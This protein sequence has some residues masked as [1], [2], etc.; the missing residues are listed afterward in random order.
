MLLGTH[1]PLMHHCKEKKEIHITFLGKKITKQEYI[2]I[3]TTV[4][5]RIK[6]PIFLGDSLLKDLFFCLYNPYIRDGG[7]VIL[8]KACTNCIC[9]TVAFSP[10]IYFAFQDIFIK[11]LC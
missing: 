2:I 5:T 3:W 8:T 10:I 7:S 11:I 1:S 6:E 9:I 4:E